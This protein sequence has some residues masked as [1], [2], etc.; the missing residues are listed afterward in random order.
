ML[1]VAIGPALSGA[2][3]ATRRWV[4]GSSRAMRKG[5]GPSGHANFFNGLR[6]LK[7]IRSAAEYRVLE[8]FKGYTATA[9]DSL[10]V[11]TNITLAYEELSKR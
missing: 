5:R 2:G 6:A 1:M 7:H 4:V 10:P 11:G 9:A 8:R 3:H